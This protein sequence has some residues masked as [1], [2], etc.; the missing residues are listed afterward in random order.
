MVGNLLLRGMLAG[1]IAG[2]L[3][4][5]FAHMF[6][7]PLVDAAI[8]F[9]EA[10]AQAAGEAAEPEI[11]SRA[12]QAGLG[13][14]TGVMAYSVAVGGLFALAFAFV[15]GRFSSLS[16][17]GT[18]AVIAIAAFVAVVL[19]PGI[20]YPAN[21]PAVGN[22]DTIG[23][24]TELFF[25]M[26]VVSLA[27][28]IAAVALSRRLSERFGLWNGAIIAG[29]VYLVFIGVVLYLLPPINEVPE[30]FSA[31]VLWRFRTTSLGMHVILW[32]TLGLAFGALAEKRLAVRGGQR[33]RPATAFH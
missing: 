27:A 26:I 31:M 14:F 3:V 24:R 6:G 28:L 30:N 32:A 10:S 16:P 13:L 20:K 2:I 17:R 4:F 29:I 1:L 7:E 22:P 25:L 5:A 12:T 21:P 8:A 11:V 9:E 19:V 15:Q 23:A 18:S 33:S